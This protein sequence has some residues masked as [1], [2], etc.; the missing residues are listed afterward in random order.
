[1]LLYPVMRTNLAVCIPFGDCPENPR[2]VRP[3]WALSLAI[4]LPP[5]NCS[6]MYLT[7][8]AMPRDEARNE[9]VR[10]ALA[11]KVK[12]IMFLDDDT[13]APSFA[14]RKLIYELD[15]DPSLGAIGGIY[16]TKEEIP[17]PTVIVE[18]GDGPFWNWTIGDVFP[19]TRIG[20][21]C[22]IIRA[23]VFKNI[24][25]PWFK[26]VH[27]VEQGLELGL[28]E[29]DVRG[30]LPVRFTMTDDVYFFRKFHEAGYTLKA[31]G[32]VLAV[33]WDLNGK[34]YELPESS[35]PVQSFFMQQ[36]AKLAAVPA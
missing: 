18:E 25:E 28:V 26:D 12:Y 2:P 35:Y 29:P 11:H 32:G 15:Q 14:I 6:H 36:R 16:C 17:S 34:F 4:M 19:C 7:V 3:E 10:Q 8:R 33:H 30:D 24:P 1:M 9:L 22:V 27:S 21:G 23:D 13:A 31:H 20:T 5:M